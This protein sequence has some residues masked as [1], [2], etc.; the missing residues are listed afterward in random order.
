MRDLRVLCLTTALPP[1]IRFIE[2]GSDTISP[3]A[4]QYVRLEG[5]SY[6]VATSEA[7][8]VETDRNGEFLGRGQRFVGLE[9]SLSVNSATISRW[10]YSDRQ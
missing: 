9:S 5:L 1:A 3:S 2:M 7:G 10:I 6:N 4:V 8:R